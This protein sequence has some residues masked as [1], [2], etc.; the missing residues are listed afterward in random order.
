WGELSRSAAQL[1]LLLVAACRPEPIRPEVT[2]LRRALEAQG[3]VL[4]QLGPLS[5]AQSAELVGELT[6]AP[7]GPRLARLA[8]RAG[9]NPMYVRELVDVLAREGRLRVEPGVVAEVERGGELPVPTSLRAAI[10]GRIGSMSENTQRTVRMAALLGAE[11]S[12]ADLAAVLR[13]PVPDLADALLE[14]YQAHVLV[15][16]GARTAF[17]HPLIR[18]ALHEAIP[19]GVRA[20]L[21]RQAAQALAEAGVAVERVGEQLQTAPG[22]MDSWVL[23][24]LVDNGTALANRASQPAVDLLSRAADHI[25]NTDPRRE[26]IESLL[27]VALR[28]MLRFEELAQRTRAVLADSGISTGH[29]LEMSWE[30]AYSLLYSDHPQA[31]RVAREALASD[32]GSGWGARLR[33]VLAAVLALD[34]RADDPWPVIRDAH[35][36]AR[37]TGDT[38]A[39]AFTLNAESIVTGHNNAPAAVDLLQRGLAVIRDEPQTADLRSTMLG[40]LLFYLDELG[41]QAEADAALATLLAFVAKFPSAMAVT[42]VQLTAAQRHYDVGRWD[43]VVAELESVDTRPEQGYLAMDVLSIGVLVALHRDDRAAMAAGLGSLTE[44]PLDD[45]TVRNHSGRMFLARALAAE[46]DGQPRQAVALLAPLLDPKL[47]MNPHHRMRWL[48]DLVRLALALGERGIAETATRLAA[49]HADREAL[50][51]RVAVATQCRGLLTADPE[52]LLDAAD[53][54]KTACRPLDRGAALENAAVMFGERGSLPEARAAVAAAL[55]EYEKLGAVWDATRADAR[56]RPFG[57]RR[58]HRG[59]RGRPATGWDALT[60]TELRVASF[61]A[62]GLTNPAIAA[63]LFLS[64][65]TVQTHVSHILV[66]LGAHSRAEVASEAARHDP[67]VPGGRA[68]PRSRSAS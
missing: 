49:D 39:M 53:L 20:A 4:V 9:G 6:G 3:A 48:A 13:C 66:K 29:R 5:R 60:P 24:W 8:A 51:W 26:T 58:G 12:A 31:V 18:Q 55:G 33:A 41:Q 44:I 28:R 19:A 54:F 14:A 59:P 56:M 64:R 45:A 50:P 68:A 32:D 23:G 11:F 38:W 57:V 37:R 2:R 61:V 22:V 21:H 7:P 10:D 17:R 35:A 16:S 52:L 62:D 40:N 46:R 65:R 47:D 63:E 34:Q 27:V 36:A 43:D 67:G 15:D 1:P 42:R 25:P 30:L